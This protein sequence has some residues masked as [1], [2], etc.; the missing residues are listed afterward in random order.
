MAG[1]ATT[2]HRPGHAMPFAAGPAS[3]RDGYV[4]LRRAIPDDWLDPLRTAFDGGVVAASDWPVPR[5][6]GL[7]HAMVDTDPFVQRVCRLPSVI[8]AVSRLLPEPFFLA[9]VEG[10]E[11]MAGGGAQLLHRDAAG[12]SGKMVSALAFLDA[13]GPA[14][15]A[16]RL[17]PG[18][19]RSDDPADVPD[20][21][22][23]ITLEGEA[24]DI[25]VFDAD[26]L[27]GGTRNTSGARRRSLLI[28]YLAETLR[29]DDE[30][31]RDLRGIR[32]PRS[33]TFGAP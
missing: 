11:P 19:Q 22:R 16:T 31:T 9:Q 24:R 30:A 28:S 1:G 15:G 23:A 25:L 14:N 26:L 5:G 13:Y 2:V 10:R 27:H 29:A 20:H 21:P 3:A 6:Q 7:R 32:M 18:S 33:E 4:L 17:V 8:D 12:A